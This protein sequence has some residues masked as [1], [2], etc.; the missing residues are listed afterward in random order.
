MKDLWMSDL[1]LLRANWIRHLLQQVVDVEASLN[2]NKWPEESWDSCWK[3][4]HPNYKLLSQVVSSK[5]GS[6]V[7]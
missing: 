1:E 7:S 6:L 3:T 4:Y 2:L 5:K